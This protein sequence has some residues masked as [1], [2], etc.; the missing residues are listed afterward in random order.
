MEKGVFVLFHHVNLKPFMGL[1]YLHN[2]KSLGSILTYSGLALL[3]L[4]MLFIL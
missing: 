3:Y 2:I 4:L 1:I